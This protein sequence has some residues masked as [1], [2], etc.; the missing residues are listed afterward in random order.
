MSK[1][2]LRFDLLQARFPELYREAKQKIEGN[3]KPS[4]ILADWLNELVYRR[5]AINEP[6][7]QEPTPETDDLDFAISVMDSLD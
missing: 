5:Q 6:P 3:V 1:I 4:D 2:H 7:Y